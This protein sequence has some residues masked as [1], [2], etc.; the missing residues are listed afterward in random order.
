M[1][2]DVVVDK[3]VKKIVEKIKDQRFQELFKKCRKR[4]ELLGPRGGQLLN[5]QYHLFEWKNYHPPLRVYFRIRTENEIIILSCEY[6]TSEKK[7][8]ETIT[9]LLESFD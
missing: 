9:R 6:K 3:K 2:F 8:Q 1:V 5:N 7:Q 4:L